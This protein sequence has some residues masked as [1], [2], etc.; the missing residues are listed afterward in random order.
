MMN[1]DP[2]GVGDF[3]YLRETSPTSDFSEFAEGI[4]CKAKERQDRYH[5]KFSN[6]ILRRDEIE[7]DLARGTARKKASCLEEEL[8]TIEINLAKERP[9]YPA[10]LAWKLHHFE[11][12]LG[13]TRISP[14]A[15]FWLS[16]IIADVQ[17]MTDM[18]R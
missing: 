6:L 4:I 1:K 12:L 18:K 16:R 5:D 9:E 17:W 2:N 14:D 7:R 13:K 3:N 11:S 8:A 10:I 15:R